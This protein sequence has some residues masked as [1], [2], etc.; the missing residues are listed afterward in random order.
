MPTFRPSIGA[1]VNAKSLL[2]TE[3]RLT[4]FRSIESS[5]E[6][7]NKRCN[8]SFFDVNAP[9]LMICDIEYFLFYDLSILEFNKK[10]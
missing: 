6:K 1:I 7:L 2:Q 9:L 3:L 8:P 5:G 10:V 4:L